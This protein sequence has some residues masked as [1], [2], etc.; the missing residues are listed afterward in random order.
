MQHKLED[1]LI[2]F[3][4]KFWCIVYTVS[5]NISNLP[6]KMGYHSCVYS[7]HELLFFRES[8]ALASQSSFSYGA[9]RR[10]APYLLSYYLINKQSLHIRSQG[11]EIPTLIKEE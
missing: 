6:N 4:L 2:G 5:S 10:K 8:P 7:V 3:G 11:L 9:T 1:W